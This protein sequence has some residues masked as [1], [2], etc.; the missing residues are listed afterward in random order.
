MALKI[1]VAATM[2]NVI[3]QDNGLPFALADDLKRFKEKTVGYPV[4][5]GY[6]TYLSIPA[7]FRP[8][9]GRENIVLTSNP[10]KL[11]G[12]KITIAT[13]FN[14]I[15]ARAEKEDLWVIGGARV[16]AQALPKAH[17]LHLTRV[18]AIL[19]G[20]VFFPPWDS[21]AWTLTS[22][23]S[24]QAGESNQYNFTWEMWRRM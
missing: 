20:Q 14:Q 6:N 12:E 7:K 21:A 10:R 23:E 13:D 3:G 5:C 19:P 22:Q 4:V 24:I 18:Q 16:Y 9:P 11:E 17:E 8:L 1:I 2:N 15:L